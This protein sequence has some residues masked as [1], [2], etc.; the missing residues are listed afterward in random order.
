MSQPARQKLLGAKAYFSPFYPIQN[1][2]YHRTYGPSC[3]SVRKIHQLQHQKNA[4]QGQRFSRISLRSASTSTTTPSS[5]QSSSAPHASS[6]PLMSRSPNR[7]LPTLPPD[8]FRVWSRTLPVF[9][10][11]VAVS[12]LAIFNYQKSNSS[13]VAS[14]L[15]ALRRNETAHEILGDEIYFA[16]SVPWI[17]GEM[18]QLH[19]RIDIRFWVKGTKGK[20]RCRFICERKGGRGGLVSQ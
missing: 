13:T 3:R 1:S 4:K 12:A 18:D 9:F 14:I 7:P 15:Y 2:I 10:V 6:G 8:S 5:S 19:G 20:G 17:S 16:S 11:L